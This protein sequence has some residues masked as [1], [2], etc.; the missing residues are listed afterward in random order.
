[1]NEA[2]KKV[3]GREFNQIDFRLAKL[4]LGIRKEY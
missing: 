2:T 3:E 1:M 4:H